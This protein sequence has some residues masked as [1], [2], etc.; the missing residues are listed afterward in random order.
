MEREH[1]AFSP[2]NDA[3]APP[4]ARGEAL[5]FEDVPR[6]CWRWPRAWRS[7]GAIP[8][9]PRAGHAPKP[10]CSFCPKRGSVGHSTWSWVGNNL[11]G[12]CG[13]ARLPKS[14]VLLSGVVRCSH[15][16]P[17]LCR[18]GASLPEQPSGHNS[19]E[20]DDRGSAQPCNEAEGESKSSVHRLPL[21]S[22]PAFGPRQ[23]PAQERDGS[24]RL[25]P[26]ESCGRS[27]SKAGEGLGEAL[28][29]RGRA[30]PERAE[31]K[32]APWRSPWGW[33]LGC[34]HWA[35]AAAAAEGRRQPP[36]RS[37][38]SGECPP[39]PS[40]SLRPQGQGDAPS[41]APLC[42]LPSLSPF[43]LFFT[44]REAPGWG[45]CVQGLAPRAVMP[46]C[47]LG[48]QTNKWNKV[49]REKLQLHLP[50]GKLQGR[51]SG[52][53]SPWGEEQRGGP[54]GEPRTPQAGDAGVGE[55]GTAPAAPWRGAACTLIFI[56]LFCEI[57]FL[58]CQAQ[59]LGG[60]QTRAR[61][62]LGFAPCRWPRAW[63]LSVLPQRRG[64]RGAGRTR[65]DLF[66]ERG[67]TGAAGGV[68]AP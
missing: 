29:R 63:H 6:A 11:W 10:G 26:W 15:L 4:E 66:S 47:A 51:A 19:P 62:E 55:G 52:L 50:L 18:Q 25:R 41:P 65:G 2:R 1:H 8:H 46:L 33:G 12:V 57:S 5:S 58:C 48:S 64:G 30:E 27:A 3:E 28:R 59:R 22:L 43:L 68:E 7:D 21:A 56:L 44:P 32:E 40:P 34:A 54:T 42:L 9:G 23:A 31:P 14:S 35:A 37:R 17:V 49:L 16:R 60:G 61:A 67:V 36:R 45:V 24:Q 53:G 39:S 20:G 38:C 13:C